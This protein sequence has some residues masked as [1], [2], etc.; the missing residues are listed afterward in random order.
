[1]RWAA[2]RAS[3]ARNLT[4]SWSPRWNRPLTPASYACLQSKFTFEVISASSR[5]D[6]ACSRPELRIFL[7]WRSSRPRARVAQSRA[8]KRKKR[9]ARLRDRPPV[10]SLQRYQDSPSLG[11][12]VT[13]VGNGDRGAVE[14]GDRDVERLVVRLGA[15]LQDAYA[16][17]LA[18]QNRPEGRTAEVDAGVNPV[19]KRDVERQFVEL[20][21]DVQ[22]V[23]V[24][25]R[26]GI[27]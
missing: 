8:E 27:E 19:T 16:N 7:V 14:L 4:A 10:D 21:V 23:R 13:W 2:S 1:M 24:R 22:A 6:S 3:R 18:Q 9:A 12:W 25:A 15:I 17:L 5:S 26:V 20:S 11:L